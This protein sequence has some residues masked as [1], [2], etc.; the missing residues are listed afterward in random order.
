[1]TSL[2]TLAQ[3]SPRHFADLGL[4]ALAYV[5]AV[6]EDGASLFAIHAADGT[7]IAAVHDR[8]T[9]FVLVRQYDLEPVS[10]Q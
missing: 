1:M 6:V 8:A 5:K 10:V 3:L 4:T 2:S 9:A 7:R